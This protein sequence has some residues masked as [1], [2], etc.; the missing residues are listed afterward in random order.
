MEKTLE[1]LYGLE[2]REVDLVRVETI[3]GK[4]LEK[5]R[6]P[7]LCI[8]EIDFPEFTS[9][10]PKTSQ[11]DFANIDLLYIPKDWCVEMKAL[12]YYYNS[13]RNEGHFYEEVAHIIYEDL[14][15]VL[16]PVKMRVTAEFNVRGGAGAVIEVGDDIE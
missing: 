9:L 11:P 10:C 13:F 8:V 16:D 1:E 14:K 4:W 15:G 12:K 5:F 6:S 2:K 3:S 7:G